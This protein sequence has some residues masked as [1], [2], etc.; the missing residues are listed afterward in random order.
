MR[1][2]YENHGAAAEKAARLRPIAIEQFS[3][4]AAARKLIAIIE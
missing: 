4:E 2:V 3:W 1:W